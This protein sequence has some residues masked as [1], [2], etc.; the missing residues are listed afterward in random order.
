[1]GGV[2]TLA[3]DRSMIRVSVEYVRPK[4]RISLVIFNDDTS[5][6]AGSDKLMIKANTNPPGRMYGEIG[7]ISP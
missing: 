5:A 1:M 2:R 4:R 3:N 6:S 7:W